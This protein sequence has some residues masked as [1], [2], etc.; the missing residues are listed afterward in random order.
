M[1]LDFNRP[2]GQIY[3]HPQAVYEQ[4]GQLFDGAGY[5]IVLEDKTVEESEVEEV[6][7]EQKIDA[8]KFLNDTLYGAAI[9]ESKLYKLAQ[10]AGLQWDVVK[11]VSNEMTNIR[12]Y[13]QGNSTMWKL[14]VD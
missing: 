5:P 10:D 6:S 7:K 11:N 8:E 12:K 9:S 4:D 13:R 2:K 1:K 14:L 3:G